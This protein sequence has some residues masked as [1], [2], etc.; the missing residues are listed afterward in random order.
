MK[1]N[2]GKVFITA[3]MMVKNE[4][5]N[6]ER[7]LKSIKPLVDEIIIVDTG[8]EDDTIKI[9]ESFGARVFIHPWESD[10]S[11]HRNQSISYAS[12]EW[13]LIIDADEEFVAKNKKDNTLDCDCLRDFCRLVQDKQDVVAVRVKDI[14]KGKAVMTF[15]SARI[16]KKECIHYEGIVHNNPITKTTQSVLFEDV[17]IRHYGYDLTPEQKQK[18]YERTNSLLRKRIELDPKDYQAMF[19]LCQLHAESG[20]DSIEAMKWGEA[21]IAAKEEIKKDGSN[22]FNISIYFT[23]FRVYMSIKNLAKAKETIQNAIK[24]F[25]GDLDIALA[26]VEY[27]IET[28]DNK[29]KMQGIEGFLDKWMEYQAN[30][31]ASGN[32]FVYSFRPEGLAFIL[33]QKAL[34][35]FVEGAGSINKLMEVL[36]IMP[37][38]ARDMY[39]ADLQRQLNEAGVPLAINFNQ[40][41]DD[42]NI[43]T[44]NAKI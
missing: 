44:A 43:V 24:E 27:G 15:N 38:Q 14:Q 28:K 6:L 23:V 42:S 17:I 7:C 2:P 37:S 3:C 32:A 29:V 26:I 18:K 12:G 36:N 5:A 31:T 30:P 21:Y 20:R 1:E 10:F 33:Q 25:G 16:F 34:A 13:I 19:Y 22:R 35:H 8:S 11:K 41:V 9:A 4:Q 40:P 39:I